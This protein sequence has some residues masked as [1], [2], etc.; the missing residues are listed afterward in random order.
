[1]EDETK[2]KLAKAIVFAVVLLVLAA[3]YIPWIRA[4]TRQYHD[5]VAYATDTI[6]C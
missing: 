3:V 6:N 2:D 5:C 4:D 1:M